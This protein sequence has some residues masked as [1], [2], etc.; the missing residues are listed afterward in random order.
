MVWQDEMFKAFP[1]AVRL[2]QVSEKV[3]SSLGVKGFRPENTLFANCTC[4]D[5]INYRG[6][7]FF[8]DFWGENFD[9]AGLGGY[10]TSGIT[11]FTAYSHHVPDG[12]N[13][14]ICRFAGPV[15]DQSIQFVNPFGQPARLVI[16][17]NG[18]KV[19]EDISI[20][21]FDDNPACLFGPVALTTIK[22]PLFKIAEDSVHL[23]SAIMAGSGKVKKKTVVAPE[24]VI[25]E[26]CAAYKS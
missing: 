26:S 14:F 19:P 10:P 22:Q 11:G 21:G 13:L 3:K 9:L 5:E 8:A 25:R 2:D 18:L 20:I 6:I 23:L 1:Q 17:E 24:L 7:S 16:M 15:G 4:R 12:G